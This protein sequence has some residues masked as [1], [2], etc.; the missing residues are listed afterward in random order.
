MLHAGRKAARVRV[1][2]VMWVKIP[3]P[4]RLS[5]NGAAHPAAARQT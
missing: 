3:R 5:A 2:H 4:G 1:C